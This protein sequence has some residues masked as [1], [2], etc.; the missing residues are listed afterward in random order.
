MKTGNCPNG[1]DLFNGLFYDTGLITDDESLRPFERRRVY[2]L[3]CIM[4]RL[5]LAGLLLQLKDKKYTPHIVMIISALTII[6]LSTRV[7]NSQWWS[8]D[9][10][11][12][13]AQLLFVASSLIVCG[14]NNIPTSSL[15]VIFYFSIFGGIFQSL[16]IPSC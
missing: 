11:M 3:V 4:L 16:L 12:F 8:I 5:F 1:D 14:C 7:N 13:I 6:N 10:Q 2:Y 15:A 9:F